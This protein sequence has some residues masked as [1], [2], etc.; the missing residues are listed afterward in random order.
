MNAITHLTGAKVLLVSGS[1]VVAAVI[2]VGV[3]AAISSGSHHVPSS[4]VVVHPGGH[5]DGFHVSRIGLGDV[6]ETPPAM[7]R[8]GP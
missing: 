8:P 6:T 1:V 7:Q 5:D 3:N 2:G 4:A